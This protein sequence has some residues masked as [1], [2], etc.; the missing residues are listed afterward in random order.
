[1][2]DRIKVK[3]E[4]REGVWLVEQAEIIRW[5]EN[6]D[7]DQI[8]NYLSAGPMLLGAD[9]DKDTVIEECRKAERIA[10][11]TGDAWR[12]QRKHALAVIVS[13]TLKI[14]DIGEITTDDLII[15]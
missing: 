13:N 1:M 14:F 8:H 9:W 3:P 11:L 2:S 10:V 12:E 5:L 7:M 6:S 4:G 15:N